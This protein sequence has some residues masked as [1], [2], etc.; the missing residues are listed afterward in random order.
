MYNYK[1]NHFKTC[2]NYLYCQKFRDSYL[3]YCSHCLNNELIKSSV[4]NYSI[5]YHI[6]KVCKKNEVTKKRF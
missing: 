2:K 5:T 1:N 3:D 6:C 4:I